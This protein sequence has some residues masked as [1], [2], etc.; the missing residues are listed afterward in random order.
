[1]L[2]TVWDRLFG[3]Y[4]T[5]TPTKDA[6]RVIGLEYFRDV[7]SARLDR[8]L[9]QPFLSPSVRRQAVRSEYDGGTSP[10]P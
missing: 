7:R 4:V 9:G 8:V 2:L 6:D 3:T 5:S 1:M 10:A